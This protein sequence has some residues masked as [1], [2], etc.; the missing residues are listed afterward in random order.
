MTQ[1]RTHKRL[2]VY[3]ALMTAWAYVRLPVISLNAL[4][5]KYCIKTTVL[6][7]VLYGY[8]IS[9][10][11]HREMYRLRLFGNI[12]SREDVTESDIIR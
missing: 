4:R 9:S 11:S 5:V 7:V 2:Y 1:P 8:K 12:F 10:V 3:V 6:P